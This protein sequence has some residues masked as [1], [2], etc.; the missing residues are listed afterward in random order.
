MNKLIKGRRL[1]KEN[2]R[3][4]I[5]PAYPLKEEPSILKHEN[6]GLWVFL[7]WKPVFLTLENVHSQ[8][9]MGW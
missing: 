8:V 9:G 4:N 5:F 7:Y 2:E 3:E 6:H 1:S